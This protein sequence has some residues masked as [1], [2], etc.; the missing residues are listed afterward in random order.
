MRGIW[1][2]QSAKLAAQQEAR[3]RMWA[4]AAQRRSLPAYGAWAALRL[5]HAVG[6]NAKNT[7][8]F[9]LILFK[10]RARTTCCHAHAF[11]CDS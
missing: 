2:A 8:L 3:R 11:N 9:S 10:V 5:G 6:N 4:D 1:R 7:L